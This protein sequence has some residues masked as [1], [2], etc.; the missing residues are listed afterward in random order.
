MW[1]K[2]LLDA[3]QMLFVFQWIAAMPDVH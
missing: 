3:A 2:R 1:V